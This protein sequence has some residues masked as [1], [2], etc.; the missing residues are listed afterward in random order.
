ML[1]EFEPEIKN[2]NLNISKIYKHDLPKVNVDPKLIRIVLQNLLTNAI[3]Y[4]GPEG[5]ISLAIEITKHE[6]LIT[7]SDSGCGIRPEDQSKI[8]DKFYRTEFARQID[9]N[10]NGLGLYIVKAIVEQAQGK[11]WLKSKVDKGTTFYIMLP[12]DGMKKRDG[13]QG[14][15]ES[16]S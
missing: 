3:K 10:G 11:I 2:K 12:V 1:Q 14:L 6:I 15:N 4:T 8:F 16:H 9:P 13:T 5:K 7:V